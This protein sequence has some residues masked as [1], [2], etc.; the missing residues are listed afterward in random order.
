M[1]VRFVC[2][3]GMYRVGE[4]LEL[5]KYTALHLLKRHIVAP[6]HQTRE[7]AVEGAPER[8]VVH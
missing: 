2:R 6:V 7:K 1:K 8:A 5:D 4:E 3:W